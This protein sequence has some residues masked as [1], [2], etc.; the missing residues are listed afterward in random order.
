MSGTSTL[1]GR[2]FAAGEG[3]RLFTD[4]AE[5][6]A[7]L[8]VEGA[9]AQVQGRLGVIPETAGAAIHRASLEVT[10]DPAALAE[11][12]RRN[13]V[14]VP[15]LVAAFREAMG[16]PEHAQYV[17]WGAT[18]QDI[19]DTALMLR[20]RQALTLAENALAET[21]GALGA[22]AEAH[23]ET[24]M[25]ARTYGQ[26][27]TPTSF[28][29]VAAGW[30]WPLLELVEELEALR[31]RCLW[32]SLSG[33]AGTG[34]ALGAMAAD[35]RAG[36][37]A[38]LGLEDPGRSWHA[39]RGPV[40]R[41]AGWAERLAAALG[42]FAEDLLLMTQSGLAELRLGET[43]GSSTMPQ[44]ANP[45]G[46]SALL[47]LTRKARAEAA[48]LAQA[49]SPRQNRDGAAWFTEWLALPALWRA[50]LAAAT[51]GQDIAGTLAPDTGAMAAAL[52]AG[53]GAPYAEALSFAL[54][55]EMPRPEAQA[56]A[57]R[58]AAEAA[59][60]GRPLAELARA[61][62]PGLDPALFTPARQLGQAPAEARAFAAAVARRG[63]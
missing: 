53:G 16:A 51:R 3:A 45:V 12:T 2:L 58:L 40:L 62:H 25:A 42:K 20:L 31:P 41:L 18:S 5:L 6:R 14:T 10:L 60:R 28:G 4:A 52:A 17:H 35:T 33:A 29:A 24:P 26:V 32:V 61:A 55:G 44:K 37:A 23:A 50:I 34:A 21:A 11:P 15:G 39:D 30:G 46:P 59:A 7:M 9:L 22:L 8:L 13:G 54:A 38:A 36:L 19:Q 47:A 49:G 43:G 56:E 1:Y 48:L 27:A 63:A 57:S